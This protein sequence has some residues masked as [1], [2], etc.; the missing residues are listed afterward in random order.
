MQYISKCI[1]LNV[2]QAAS[3]GDILLIHVATLLQLTK[4]SDSTE[5]VILIFLK[6]TKINRAVT[7]KIQHS[8]QVRK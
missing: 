1:T 4:Q 2:I 5:K 8:S 6:H 7:Q 3:K